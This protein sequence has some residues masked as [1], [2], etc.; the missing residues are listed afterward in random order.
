MTEPKPII[1]ASRS[2]RRIEAI[3][4]LTA[5]FKVVAANVE[6]T[7]DSKL[8]PQEN[9]L[10]IARRKALDV[11]QAHPGHPVLG[12]DTLV[13][14]QDK[15]IGKPQDTGD[16]H[17][18]L[19]QLSGKKHQ[20]ITGVVL[21]YGEACYEEAAVSSVH[22]RPQNDKAITDYIASGEPMDKAG[23]YAIQGKG[24]VLVESY[25]GS[26]S[27]IVGFPVDTVKKLLRQAGVELG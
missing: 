8:S 19:K 25:E 20:V 4:K 12:A 18:I 27:N 15:I 16:A 6:E 24:A 22:I 1:L 17:R 7:L 13:V 21:I 14:L 3:G 2:P 5:N 10:A 11:A 26:Y 9:A 23:A